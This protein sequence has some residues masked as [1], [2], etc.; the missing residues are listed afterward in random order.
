MATTETKSVRS[1]MAPKVLGV[2]PGTPL[3]AALRLMTELCVHHLPVIDGARCIGL[4]SETDVLWSLWTHGASTQTAADCCRGPGPSVSPD[5]PVA[6]A[7]A[8]MSHHGSDAAL[9]TTNG[10]IVGIITATDIVHHLAT[11]AL[12]S[13][14]DTTPSGQPCSC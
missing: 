10:H 14:S 13:R 9:V 11:H 3:E 2:T 7:A 6:A 12:A 5:D 4:L 8:R 1:I